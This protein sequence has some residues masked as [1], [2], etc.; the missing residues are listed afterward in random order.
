MWELC[1]YIAAAS[2]STPAAAQRYH[3]TGWLGVD[4]GELRGVDVSKGQVFPLQIAS[5]RKEHT[6]L[7]GSC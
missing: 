2:L 3:Q 5:G 6:F 1:F 4:T 7:I